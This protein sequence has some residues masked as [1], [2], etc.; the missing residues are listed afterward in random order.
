MTS[1]VVAKSA[2]GPTVS[3][4]PAVYQYL[5]G[6]SMRQTD[7]E[8]RMMKEIEAMDR[9]MMIGAPEEAQFLGWLLQT[10]G[11]K[12]V[13]EV[14]VFRGSTTLK[15][16]MSLP[17]DGKIYALDVS[18]DFCEVGRRYWKEAGVEQKIE[19]MIAPAVQSMAKLLAS[20]HEGTFDFI[21][22]DADKNNYD[23]YYEMGLKLV[24]KGGVIAIDNTLWHGRILDQEALKS[25]ADTIAIHAIN[26][27]TQAD[28]RVAMSH[29]SIADGVVLCTKL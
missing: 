6:T 10:M 2:E 23:N 1:G 5:L 22:I 29:V 7:L 13:L 25:D 8:K 9:A 4:V 19:L 3:N 26:V 18:A 20:G 11:A 21:F 16:A 28:T 12:K 24:R 15:M 27:K 17:G 14:G